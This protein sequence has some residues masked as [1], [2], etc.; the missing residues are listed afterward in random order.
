MQP[1]SWPGVYELAWTFSGLCYACVQPQ[2]GRAINPPCLDSTK[3][4]TYID[5]TVGHEYHPPLQTE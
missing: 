1:Q 2:A 5:N 3:I 4:V